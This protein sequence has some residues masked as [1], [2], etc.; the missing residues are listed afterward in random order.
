MLTFGLLGR[1]IAPLHF[2]T[3]TV[4]DPHLAHR[5]FE[6]LLLAFLELGQ[7]FPVPGTLN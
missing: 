7:Y 3:E 5:D 2:K 1:N 4:A 6:Q